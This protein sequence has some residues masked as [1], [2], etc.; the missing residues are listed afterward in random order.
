MASRRAARPLCSVLSAQ[1]PALKQFHVSDLIMS[2]ADT[3]RHDAA[4]CDTATQRHTRQERRGAACSVRNPD[5]E[6][7]TSTPNH[8]S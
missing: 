2:V 8:L 4:R 7:K 3:T 6:H 5:P 1:Q